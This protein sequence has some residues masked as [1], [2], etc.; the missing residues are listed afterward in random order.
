M[1][2]IYK[3]YLYYSYTS[4]DG[5]GIIDVREGFRGTLEKLQEVLKN[6]KQDFFDVRFDGWNA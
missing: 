2:R 6:L 1:N 4:L 3:G 5:K